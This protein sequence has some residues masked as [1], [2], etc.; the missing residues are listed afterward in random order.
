MAAA[1]GWRG[2]RAGYPPIAASDIRPGDE[3]YN[4]SPRGYPPQG[5]VR[6]VFRRAMRANFEYTVPYMTGETMVLQAPLWALYGAYVGRRVEGGEPVFYQV[7]PRDRNPVEMGA[8]RLSRWGFLDRSRVMLGTG[9]DSHH[10]VLARRLGY[11]G[12]QGALMSGLIAFEVYRPPFGSEFEGWSETARNLQTI[13]DFVRASDDVVAGVEWSWRS[14]GKA[15][16]ASTP[17]RAISLL[18]QRVIAKRPS[19]SNPNSLSNPM[20]FAAF[21]SSGTVLGTVTAPNRQEARAK[22]RVEGARLRLPPAPSLY[23]YPMLNLKPEQQY[24]ARLGWSI[25]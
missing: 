14:S 13:L 21:N 4:P 15:G 24:A 19:V 5:T 9:R 7:P 22:L 3:I 23:L 8:E 11:K 25:R 6:G 10:D 12:K 1:T 18:A 20:V 2:I 16:S 17:E